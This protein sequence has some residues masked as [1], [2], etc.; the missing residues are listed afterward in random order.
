MRV[1]FFIIPKIALEFVSFVLCCISRSVGCRGGIWA[2]NL[3]GEKRWNESW[4]IS[5][6]PQENPRENVQKIERTEREKL[7][8]TESRN[9][10][11]H[12]LC[13]SL[14]GWLNAIRH[15]SIPSNSN[16]SGSRINKTNSL[17]LNFR[18]N[19]K[20]PPSD[21][22]WE[23]GIIWNIQPGLESSVR[24]CSKTMSWSIRTSTWG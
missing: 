13:H 5:K 7:K 18:T 6:F 17:L 11:S 14:L 10:T 24:D 9:P 19:K 3:F 4:K 15:N 23:T 21:N 12:S 1:D 20:P 2:G 22:K 8:K 16:N